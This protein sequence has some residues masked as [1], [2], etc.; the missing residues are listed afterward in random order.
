[1]N[2]SRTVSRSIAISLLLLDLLALAGC[3]VQEGPAVRAKPTDSGTTSTEANVTPEVAQAA[4]I[5]KRE[6]ER[7]PLVRNVIWHAEPGTIRYIAFTDPSTHAAEEVTLA[8][9]LTPSITVSYSPG[10]TVTAPGWKVSYTEYV[11]MHE[12]YFLS[13]TW[14]QSDAEAV[15]GALRVLVRDARENGAEVIAAGLEKFKV[16]CRSWRQE[17][18]PM[19]AEA[20]QHMQAARDAYQARDLDKAGDEYLAALKDFPCWPEG[21]FNA[22]SILGETGWYTGAVTHMRRYLELVPDAS[23]AQAARDKIVEWTAKT[24][25]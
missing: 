13:S 17:R 25:S 21:Q 4:K 15:A 12:Y 2:V 20:R 16:T 24:G 7:T 9:V 14:S 11:Q 8:T 23:D 22:A 3:V 10:S 19:P 6:L 1:M 18:A 5:F